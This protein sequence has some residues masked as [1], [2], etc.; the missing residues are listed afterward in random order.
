MKPVGAASSSNIAASN[1]GRPDGIDAIRAHSIAIGSDS[2]ATADDSTA[3][4]DNADAG[5]AGQLADL[6]G[7]SSFL[8]S[9]SPGSY[10][11]YVKLPTEYKERLHQDYLAT[12]DLDRIKADIFKY[13]REVKR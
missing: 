6:E 5:G 13:T 9:K 2:D 11:F 1:R 12:G 8:Q 7:F 10:I 4:G 3:I